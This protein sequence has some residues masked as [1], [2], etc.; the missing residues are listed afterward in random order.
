M[1]N[2]Y[3]KMFTYVDL[4]IEVNLQIK[5]SSRSLPSSGQGT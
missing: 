2:I 4:I 3:A 1:L 5:F